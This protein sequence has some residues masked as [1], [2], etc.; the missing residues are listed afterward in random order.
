LSG[1]GV[2]FGAYAGERLVGC[3]VLG[4]TFRGDE[5]DLLQID[6]LYVTREYRRQGIGKRLMEV[7]SSEDVRRGAAGLY[8]SSTETE[9]AVNFY[10]SCGSKLTGKPDP[11]L[12]AREPYEIHMAKKF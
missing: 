10:R 9:S 5:G 11:E 8:I 4:H 3:G 7:L 1:G 12:L 6:L 2:A